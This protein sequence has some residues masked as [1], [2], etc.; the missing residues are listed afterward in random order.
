MIEL[1]PVETVERIKP[2]VRIVL[3]DW[4][5]KFSNNFPDTLD[6]V[7]GKTVRIL[8][9]QQ[10]NYQLSWIIREACYRDINLSNDIPAGE[11]LYPDVADN[12]YEVLIGFK[13]GNY[14]CQVY[15]PADY[16]LYRLDYPNM[17]PLIG[18]DSLK[19]LGAIQP[20]DSPV[21]NP[22]FKLYLVYKL[23]P[24][25]LRLY[26]DDGV[27]Y[28]KITLDFTINRCLMQQGT[29]PPNVTPKPIQYLDE[30]KWLSLGAGGG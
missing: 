1:R 22:I 25:I 15:F 24:I 28:E 3:P 13:P 18:S 19:Y 6:H 5:L 14:L 7:K 17:S 2:A 26:A 30:I 9:E 10:V 20:K 4:W 23:K 12:L 16:P 21:D 29:P 8:K 11:Q 27:D